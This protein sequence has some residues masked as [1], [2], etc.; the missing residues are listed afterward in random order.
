MELIFIETLCHR[1]F[2]HVE[3]L[4][5]YCLM[6]R[7]QGLMKRSRTSVIMALVVLRTDKWLLL[8]TSMIFKPSL[9]SC[10]PRGMVK[11]STQMSRCRGACGLHAAA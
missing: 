1:L 9:E 6:L 7:L 10:I 3:L 2:F 5:M 4:P 11:N 8:A